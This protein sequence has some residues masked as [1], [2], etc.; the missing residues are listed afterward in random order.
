MILPILEVKHIIVLIYV[1]TIV[2]DRDILL[3]EMDNVY[4]DYMIL[5]MRNIVHAI[6]QKEYHQYHLY[7]EV[8]E[9]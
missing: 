6:V 8:E 9:E 2:L 5:V 3:L 4:K 7:Q 1:I